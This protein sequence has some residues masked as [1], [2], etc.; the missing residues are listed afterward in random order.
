M[1]NQA[2]M[3]ILLS[4]AAPIRR[5]EIIASAQPT[6]PTS[7]TATG[8]SGNAACASH[9]RIITSTPASPTSTAARRRQPTTSPNNGTDSRVRNNG[10]QN[11]SAVF[12]ASGKCP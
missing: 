7:T 10:M 9:G 1:P 12:V 5:M 3:A 8:H 4:P 11:P 2:T 6:T